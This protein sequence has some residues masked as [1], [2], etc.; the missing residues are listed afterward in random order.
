MSELNKNAAPQ[1]ADIAL[2]SVDAAKRETLRKLVLGAVF[3]VPVVASF[4][5]DG[6]VSTARAGCVAQSGKP[7]A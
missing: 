1:S 7:C 4:S 2:A 6:L 5:I 3:V